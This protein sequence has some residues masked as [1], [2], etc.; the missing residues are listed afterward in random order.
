MG[1]KPR[2]EAGLLRNVVRGT[3]SLA[4]HAAKVSF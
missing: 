3:T 1:R 4:P 2:I